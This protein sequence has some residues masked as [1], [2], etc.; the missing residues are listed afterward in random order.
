MLIAAYV[1]DTVLIPLL[2]CL[3]PHLYLYR[4][5][6]TYMVPYLYLYRHPIIRYHDYTYTSALLY[7]TILTPRIHNKRQGREYPTSMIFSHALLYLYWYI[8][9]RCHTMLVQYHT[10]TYTGTLLYDTTLILIPVLSY[11]TTLILIPVPSYLIP[12]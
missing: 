6:A 12:H 9:I 2:K 10:Y 11:D 3:I 4:Y 8:A 7:D 5:L 1:Y